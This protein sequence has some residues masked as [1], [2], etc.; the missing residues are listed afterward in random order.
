MGAS[1]EAAETLV[2]EIKHRMGKLRDAPNIYDVIQ[3]CAYCRVLGC[4]RGHLVECLRQ[5][6]DTGTG[7]IGDLKVS[8]HDFSDGAPD[9][10]GFDQHVLPSLYGFARAI[11]AAR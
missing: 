9:R 7:S 4:A 5:T 10:I 2:V 11:Y 6:Q 3:L 8:C 1:S